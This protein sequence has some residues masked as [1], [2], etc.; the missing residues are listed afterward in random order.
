M[1]YEVTDLKLPFLCDSSM[2]LTN[3]FLHFWWRFQEV[4]IWTNTYRVDCQNP[5]R[6]S[7]LWILL[8]LLDCRL[9]NLIQI[10]TVS[11]LLCRGR[12]RSSLHQCADFA[13][14]DSLH[15][16]LVTFWVFCCSQSVSWTS[17]KWASR[18][19][20]SVCSIYQDLRRSVSWRFRFNVH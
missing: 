6:N 19:D 12:I 9:S 1:L 17:V 3:T 11:F 2:T 5:P 14:L 20:V 16:M 8:F 10:S 18:D 7:L 4:F 15:D 13:T